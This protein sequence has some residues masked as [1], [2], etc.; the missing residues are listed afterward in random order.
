[1]VNTE[2]KVSVFNQYFLGTPFFLLGGLLHIPNPLQASIH[3]SLYTAFNELHVSLITNETETIYASRTDFYFETPLWS[4]ECWSSEGENSS[5]LTIVQ[6]FLFTSTD[7]A[8]WLTT[9]FCWLL[10]HSIKDPSLNSSQN[11]ILSAALN[12]WRLLTW[13]RHQQNCTTLSSSTLL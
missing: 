8:T 2:K 4:V 5:T 1:M 11:A 6:L 7:T 10:V 9:S 3:I 13:H 12:K